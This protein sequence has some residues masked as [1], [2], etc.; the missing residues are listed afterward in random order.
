MK[1][2]Y[3][4]SKDFTLTSNEN[5]SFSA[6]EISV[7][8]AIIM[9]AQ[10]VEITEDGDALLEMAP[11]KRI[12]VS[13][14]KDTATL[15]KRQQ[16]YDANWYCPFTSK[17]IAQEIM[18]RFPMAISSQIFRNGAL[19]GTWIAESNTVYGAG[20]PHIAGIKHGRDAWCITQ[21]ELLNEAITLNALMQAGCHRVAVF[22]F[23][24]GQDSGELIYVTPESAQIIADDKNLGA[25]CVFCPSLDKYAVVGA[26]AGEYDFELE[27]AKLQWQ[28]QVARWSRETGQPL[29]KLTE[30]LEVTEDE[31]EA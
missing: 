14:A 16:E 28:I 8:S 30:E 25:V 15:G 24:A 10:L 18:R 31:D 6:F 11:G 20:N 2:E 17:P 9:G 26:P 12:F 27:N 5:G 7:A 3:V 4:I 19:T 22:Y 23:P 13:A 29:P 1:K 21:S